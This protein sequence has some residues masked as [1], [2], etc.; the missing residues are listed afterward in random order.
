MWLEAWERGHALSGVAELIHEPA[1][2]VGLV[3]QV[4]VAAVATAIVLLVRATVDALLRLL[5]PLVE[6]SATRGFPAIPSHRSKDS[7]ARAAWNLRGP[8][9]PAASAS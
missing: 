3:A 6:A 9:S 2:L 4:L 7:V 8:P 1:F 5:A